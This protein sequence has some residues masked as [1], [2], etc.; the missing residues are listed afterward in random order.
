MVSRS[1]HAVD[2]RHSRHRAGHRRAGRTDSSL[3]GERMLGNLVR[4]RR[5]RRRQRGLQ[6][7]RYPLDRAADD[8]GPSAQGARRSE[9]ERALIAFK[10][11]NAA[12]T[13]DALSALSRYG[14]GARVL[15]GGQDLLF[16]IKKYIVQP[17][18]VINLKTIPGMNSIRSKP[19]ENL[20][21]GALTTLSAIARSTELQQKYSV[22]A[23]AA[24]VVA[25]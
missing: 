19:D 8:A 11:I 16:R 13:H 5:A 15:A 10:H 14:E 23:Q 4:R 12:S 18:C 20:R 21:I 7:R 2:S 3:R 22:L 17:E 6:R 1:A 25:S 24:G 9:R